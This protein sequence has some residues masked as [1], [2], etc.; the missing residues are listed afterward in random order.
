MTVS[1]IVKADGTVEAFDPAKL[2]GSLTK[3]GAT[4][5]S[6]ERIAHVILSTSASSVM[7]AE[8]YRKA[9]SM[10]RREAKPAAARY[11]LRRALLELGPSGHP[12]EDFIAELYTAEG[13][14]V[15][16]RKIVQGKCVSHEV[17]LFATRGEE[18]IAG[19]LKYHNDAF[20]KTDVKV[21][22]YVKARLD[23]VA[24]C[25][26][27][28]RTC[29]ITRGCLITNTKFTK[30][31]I[32]YG[33]CSGVE[34]IGWNYPAEGNLFDRIVASGIYPVSTLTTLKKAE[35]NLLI[36]ERIVTTRGLKERREVLR[37]IGVP[38]SRIG[39]ILAEIETLHNPVSHG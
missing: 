35:K 19:E 38:P 17:D 24:N 36:G 8:V 16:W 10:L 14:N 25:Q 3:A 18:T 33:K 9:F 6:A 32:D 7:S 15:E 22:L 27:G 34:L 37:K 21:A 12:F 39:S 13:W 2:I 31:A 28:K 4:M 11:A 23:D 29:V 20:Y 5:A 30:H 26:P 1:T